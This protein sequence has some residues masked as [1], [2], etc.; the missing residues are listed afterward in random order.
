MNIGV[1][2]TVLVGLYKVLFPRI[3]E[4]TL[5]VWISRGNDLR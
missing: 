5:F 1:L 2:K 4:L 3:L